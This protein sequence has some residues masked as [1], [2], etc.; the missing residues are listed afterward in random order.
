MWIDR[1]YY[2]SHISD[3]EKLIKMRRVLDKIEMVLS[4]HLV[5]T[6]DFRPYEVRLAK[7]ILNRFDDLAI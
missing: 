4:Q 3:G 7:S 5:E 1:E 6:T 2:T